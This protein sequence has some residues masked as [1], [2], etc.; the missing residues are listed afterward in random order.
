MADFNKRMSSY[1][2]KRSKQ[3]TG[4]FANLKKKF[5]RTDKFES[6]YHKKLRELEKKNL[7]GSVIVAEAEEK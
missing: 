3:Q 6:R 1:L 7:K 4:F 2:E 5:M